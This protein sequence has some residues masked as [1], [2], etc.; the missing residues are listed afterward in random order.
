MTR[1]VSE[2]I[3]ERLQA[4]DDRLAE[5]EKIGHPDLFSADARALWKAT[6]STIAGAIVK[7][8]W[9]RVVR[10]VKVHAAVL[11]AEAE[12]AAEPRPGS[13]L[14]EFLTMG[15]PPLVGEAT[16]GE[17]VMPAPK[18]DLPWMPH[19]SLLAFIRE[20][21]SLSTNTPHNLRWKRA[22]WAV[23]GCDDG[24]DC[25]AAPVTLPQALSYVTTFG[26]D[27]NCV[28]EALTS[29]TRHE[30]NRENG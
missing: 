26:K 21:E 12:E 20:K 28:V 10:L 16:S 8:D 19:P 5:V 18:T 23:N 27:W 24:E 4:I 13:G 14:K 17:T 15:E 3:L 9:P 29:K 2:V 7:G 22:R 30:I 25:H 1:P 11:E 6:P